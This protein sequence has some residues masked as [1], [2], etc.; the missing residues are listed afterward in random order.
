MSCSIVGVMTESTDQDAPRASVED[1]YGSP[2]LLPMA[3]AIQRR[4]AK[5][6]ADGSQICPP[7]RVE[8]VAWLLAEAVLEDFTVVERGWS[9]D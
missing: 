3:E 7:D 9:R 8:S 4:L 2:N 1:V 6:N 5:L